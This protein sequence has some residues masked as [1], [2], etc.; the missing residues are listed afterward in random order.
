MKGL[1]ILLLA[2]LELFSLFSLHISPS[3]RRCLPIPDLTYAAR[4]LSGRSLALSLVIG[5]RRF[6]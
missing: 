4:D 1:E 3:G 6:L 2:A 5:G